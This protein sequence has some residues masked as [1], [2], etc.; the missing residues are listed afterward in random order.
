MA[1]RC[2]SQSVTATAWRITSTVTVMLRMSR[3]SSLPSS[4][5]LPVTP[6]PVSLRIAPKVIRSPGLRDRSSR[7]WIMAPALVP[8]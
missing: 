8:M 6:A 1:L 4:T 2:S 3:T 7:T 5:A